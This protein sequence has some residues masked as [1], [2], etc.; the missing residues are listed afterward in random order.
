MDD[1]RDLVARHQELEAALRRFAATAAK[2]AIP[3]RLKLG[4]F[5]DVERACGACWELGKVFGTGLKPAAD[6]R[7][8]YLALPED[9]RNPAD[10]AKLVEAFGPDD[11]KTREKAA[12]SDRG[13]TVFKRLAWLFPA[14]KDALD[15]LKADNS[16]RRFAEQDDESAAQFTELFKRCDALR[17][18]DETTLSQL[19]SDWFNDSK[20]LRSGALRVQLANI[21]RAFEG[22]EEDVPEMELF[23]RYGI[24][25]NPFTS[26][27]VTFVPFV[28][29]TEDGRR[30]D[31][32]ALLFKAGMA[33][34]LPWETVKAIVSLDVIDPG[35]RF[36]TSE[37]AAPFSALVARNVPCVYTE[38][39]PNFAVTR[40]LKMFA[41][42][43]ARVVHAGDSDLDGFLIA[44]QVARAIPVDTIMAER[45]KNVDLPRRALTVTQRM[46]VEAYLARHPDP[47]HLPSFRDLL[48]RGW[49]EQE[50]FPWIAY[51][52]SLKTLL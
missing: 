11:S 31:F 14:R 47:P 2:G 6:G 33:A 40:L 21:L 43:G 17:G 24:A 26:H 44:D 52:E 41:V 30:F 4:T 39:Y 9:R 5:E 15:A 38:G 35:D 27:V 50:T 37:N 12:A 22:A 3:A 20:S 19:G 32:P 18:T 51:S 16:A 8:V 28:F 42:A 48:A 25:E 45:L 7:T 23:A 10:W 46:R 13:A 1:L 29:R 49:I 34:V 36:I